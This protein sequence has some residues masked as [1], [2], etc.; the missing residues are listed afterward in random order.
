MYEPFSH[1]QRTQRR[2]VTTS[3]AIMAPTRR[4]ALALA[5]LF[6]AAMLL[7][8]PVFAQDGETDDDAADEGEMYE[9]GGAD[10]LA[11][12]VTIR[13]K[14]GKMVL[15]RGRNPDGDSNKLIV[16][17]M[18]VRELNATG[19]VV[20]KRGKDDREAKHTLGSFRHI[21]FTVSDAW[22]QDAVMGVQAQSL[23]FDAP[24]ISGRSSLE[25]K[26]YLIEEAG[27][28]T[29]NEECDG[30][31]EDCIEEQMDVEAGMLKFTIAI[32]DWVFCDAS[33]TDGESDDFCKE[34]YSGEYIEVDMLVDAKKHGVKQ[35]D[36]G[37]ADTAEGR[38][39]GGR[40]LG[41]R[42]KP[43][44]Y[45]FGGTKIDFSRMIEVDGV[46]KE[47][48]E[49]YPLMTQSE[50]SGRNIYTFRFPRGQHLFYDPTVTLALDSAANSAATSSVG[51]IL[52]C[53]AMVGIAMRQ[54]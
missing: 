39:L 29:I 8:A 21:P 4:T 16:K 54:D 12:A 17:M 27:T 51:L 10:D 18:E 30:D 9:F 37:A 48:A 46:W 35:L 25:M 42:E 3:P 43:E 52:A 15:G 13:G 34:G 41:R 7:A 20:G 53:A 40:R 26:V 6:G 45:D 1:F 14:G 28:I 32:D 36:D 24:L 22:E 2:I 38:R 44:R 19:G 33:Q 49:G 47:M 11:P 31:Q 50:R 5:A 23:T